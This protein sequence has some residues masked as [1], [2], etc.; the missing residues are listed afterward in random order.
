MAKLVS[1][2]ELAD[3]LGLSPNRVSELKAAGVIQAEGSSR[4]DALECA[5][6][7]VAYRRDKASERAQ[8]GDKEALE[9]KLRKYR[10]NLEKDRNRLCKLQEEALSI[11]DTQST[12]ELIKSVLLSE[13]GELP[14]RIAGRMSGI[15]DMPSMA[16]EIEKECYAVLN[17]VKDKLNQEADRHE[18]N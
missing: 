12:H 11:G 5:R 8:S 15:K 14:E 4:F 3:I 16:E 9:A 13:L 6:R 2:S 10:S 17:G 7:Y 1:R 18:N